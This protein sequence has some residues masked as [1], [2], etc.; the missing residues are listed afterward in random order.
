MPLWLKMV[1]E[2]PALKMQEEQRL[3]NLR[4]IPQTK[5]QANP[6]LKKPEDNSQILFTD[7]N[8]P[9]NQGLQ[10][11]NYEPLCELDSTFFT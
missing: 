2:D 1:E 4:I 11:S 5:T 9:Q 10:T 3:K 7:L 8:A 6:E